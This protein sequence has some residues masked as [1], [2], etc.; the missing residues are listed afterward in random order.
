MAS[1]HLLTLIIFFPLLGCL[2][3]LLLHR[4][5]TQVRWVSLLVLIADMVFVAFSFTYLSRS[6]G[7][8]MP[9]ILQER[10]PWIEIL[11]ITY[12]LSLDGISLALI[13][14][15]AFLG[16]LAVLVSWREITTH[17]ASFHFFLLLT[18]TGVLG[19]FLAT[20]LFYF[21]LFWEIQ[22]IPIFFLIGGWGHGEKLRIHAAIKFFMYSIAGSLLMLIAIIGLYLIHGEQTGNYTF[23]LSELM[24]TRLSL[25]TEAWLYSAFLLSFAI[26]T[27]LFPLHAWLP[28]AH[29]TAPTAGSVDLAGLLL[30]TGTYAILR[31][32]Y[33]LFPNV[34]QKS[35]PILLGFGLAAIFYA[36]WV[37]LA[38]KDLKRLVAYSSIGHMGLIIIGMFVWTKITLTGSVLLMVN[39]GITTSALFIMIGMLAE[40]TNSREFSALGG[41]WR[42]M[43][44]FSG[45][46]LLFALATLGL[47]GLN[48]FVSEI[49]I[50]VGTFKEYP[51][52]A[53]IAFCGTVF[54]LVYALRM[55]QDTVFGQPRMEHQLYDVTP[56]EA[57]VLGM[58]AVVVLFL[59][60]HP[61]PVLRLLDAPVQSLLNASNQVLAA[62][63]M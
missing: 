44:I 13:M 5:P 8:G 40:R 12:S 55:V 11:G 45:F 4:H 38:Q 37:A 63:A 32:A 28:D 61:D 57:I 46:F 60:L 36:A 53:A 50:L 47:P 33:P 21:Y 30:K 27:P 62:Q 51:L 10:V 25:S 59:G 34:A 24:H 9:W 49:L 16:V 18:Q 22:L 48:N 58:L 17:V 41:V 43:P 54:V 29:T 31:F 3:T 2:L 35:A 15:T 14:M 26:K 6:A 39:H 52:F 42:E 1:F 23:A 20:D 7:P 56:R 19:I